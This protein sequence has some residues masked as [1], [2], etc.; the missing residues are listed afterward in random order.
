[1]MKVYMRSDFSF[2]RVVSRETAVSGETRYLG[3]NSFFTS[4]LDR[5]FEGC[6]FLH[7]NR[8]GLNHQSGTWSAGQ[9]NMY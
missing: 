3:L 5:V 9:K 6:C 2:S 7:I 1:M 4:F 8:S